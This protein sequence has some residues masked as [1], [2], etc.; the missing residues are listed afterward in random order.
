MDGSRTEFMKIEKRGVGLI[1]FIAVL[2]ISVML[3]ARIPELNE[4]KAKAS[5]ELLTLHK[6]DLIRSGP[7]GNLLIVLLEFNDLLCCPCL[8]SLLNVLRLLP[9]PIQRERTWMVIVFNSER[10]S[11]HQKRII[12][13]KVKGFV[14]GNGLQLPFGIDFSHHFD[15]MCQDGSLILLMNSE[16]RSVT[17]YP[18]P[19]DRG[20]CSQVIESLL[21]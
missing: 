1:I 11:E 9:P 6:N 20:T 3:T 17:I 8:E 16:N 15:S 5:P 12:F 19:L 18:L 2:N 10:Q 14:R 7:E 21:H 13:K 4:V